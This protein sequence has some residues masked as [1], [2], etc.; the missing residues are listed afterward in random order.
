M[1]GIQQGL[2]GSLYGAV[3]DFESIASASGTGSS[4]TITFSAIP[5]TYSHLQV[6]FIGRCTAAA[7]EIRLT[8]NSDTGANYSYH[9]LMGDGASATA[10]AWT[11]SSF[12]ELPPNSYSSLAANIY[13]AVVL[14]ILDYANTSKY[15]TTRAI[16][17]EDSNGAGYL[18]LMSG[19][20]R[21]TSAITS[22]TFKTNSGYW[23]ANSH[24]AL[25]GLKG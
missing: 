7:N 16:G 6:R 9:R 18:T 14:D 24:F 13:G 22:L 11:S 25:Y 10:N 2:I 15:K 17:G 20:W 21:S 8:F 12:I 4:D 5:A 1:A 23:E 3:G 19:N